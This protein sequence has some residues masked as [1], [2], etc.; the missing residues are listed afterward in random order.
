MPGSTPWHDDERFW[1]DFKA[2]LFSEAS[3]QQA[4]DK[5]GPLVELLG[6]EPGSAVLDLCCGAG[7]YATELAG[8]GFRVTGVDRTSSYLD[9]ARQRAE[10]AGLDL[11]LVL[12]DMREFVRPYRFDA[13]IN[14]YSSF[15]YFE[16]QDQDRQVARNVFESLKPGGRFVIETMSRENLF[17]IFQARGWEEQEDGTLVFQEREPTD[18]WSW[19]SQRWIV[20]KDSERAE[21]KVWMRIYSAAE[22]VGLLAEAGFEKVGIYG[23]VRGDP[24]N[25]DTSHLTVVVRRPAGKDG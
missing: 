3:R 2:S 13:C 4:A 22:L 18:D 6:L 5:T 23:S 20:I 25:K 24:Y 14:M 9:E 16:D 8:R 11:E 15:G 12:A 19:L 7:R 17:H 21:Y 1:Q 10:E